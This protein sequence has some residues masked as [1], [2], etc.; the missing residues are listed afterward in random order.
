MMLEREGDR[1]P[2]RPRPRGLCP[3][4]HRMVSLL[5]NGTLW[6]HHKPN[7]FY[8]RDAIWCSGSRQLPRLPRSP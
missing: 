1:D 2:L 7:S 8:L 6:N 5:T 4:C 3:E